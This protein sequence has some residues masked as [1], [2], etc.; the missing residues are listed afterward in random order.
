[1]SNPTRMTTDFPVDVS[2]LTQKTNSTSLRRGSDLRRTAPRVA[3][4]PAFLASR[5]HPLF[6]A[7]LRVKEGFAAMF[8]HASLQRGRAIGPGW[9][10][11]PR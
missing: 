10:Q 1:M 2:Y 5:P 8:P 11:V 6:Q 4:S 7:N 3:A 9:I